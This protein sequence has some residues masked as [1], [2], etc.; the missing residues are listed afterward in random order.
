MGKKSLDQAKKAKEDEFYTQYPDIQ[1]EIDAYYDYDEDA[2]RGKVVLLPC[3]DPEWSNFTKYFA[4][5]FERLGLKKLISTSYAPSVVEFNKRPTLFESESPLYDSNLRESR[6]RILTL[7]HDTTDDRKINIEDLEW[8]YLEGDGDFRSEE[9]KALR[10]EADIIVTNPPFSQFGGFVAWLF[11][12]DKKFIIVGPMNAISYKSFFPLIQANKLWFGTGFQKGNAFFST[13]TTREYA[14]G[15]FDP[16]LGLVKFR[17][18]VWYTN[19]EHG[20]RHETTP[21]MTEAEHIKFSRHKAIKGIGYQK[22]QNCDAIEVPRVDSIPSDYPGVM[23]VPM[24][25]LYSYNPDEFE[26][27]RFRHGDD[28]KDLRLADG[29]CPYFRIL[30]KHKGTKK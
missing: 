2:F 26:I 28:G 9:V 19:M 15:V 1:R 10:D 27:I 7:T 21:P 4:Q 6:G 17:N 16:E 5:N 8:S 25:F 12:A 22:Y 18:V 11:E 29:R 24:S 13:P 20:R 23:G 30:I 3:D 14:D